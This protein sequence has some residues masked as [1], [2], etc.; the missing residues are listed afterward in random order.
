MVLDCDKPLCLRNETEKTNFLQAVKDI[1]GNSSHAYINQSNAYNVTAEKFMQIK[2]LMK[3]HGLI[4]DV[5]NDLTNKLP[6]IADGSI[7]TTKTKV[8]SKNPNC[9]LIYIKGFPVYQLAP[10]NVSRTV[11]P[12]FLE[13]GNNLTVSINNEA[14]NMTLVCPT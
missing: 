14:E 8:V 5:E 12:P 1:M 9:A 7:Y 13:K 2:T 3:T 6:Q 10:S 11:F 4:A